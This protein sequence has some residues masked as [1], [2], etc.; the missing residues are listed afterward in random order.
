MQRFVS[1]YVCHG[2]GVSVEVWRARVGV[3]HCMGPRRAGGLGNHLT[4]LT[5]LAT[6]SRARLGAILSVCK[7]NAGSSLDLLCKST[8]VLVS[9]M[10]NF[11]L[12]FDVETNPGPPTHACRNQVG[13]KSLFTA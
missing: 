1:Y 2:M 10:V 8:L 5:L 12:M 13:L 7:W 3:W 6:L 11:G 4:L 9:A